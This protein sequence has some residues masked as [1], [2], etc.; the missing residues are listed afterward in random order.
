MRTRAQQFRTL[1]H[2]LAHALLHGEDNAHSRPERE[3][4]AESTA[5]VVCHALGLDTGSYSFPYV[6]TWGASD[7]VLTQMVGSGQRITTTAA[8]ILDALCEKE[9][10]LQEAAA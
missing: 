6:A 2:E 4:E 1:A 9:S 7:E 8:K 5:F 3:I 10:E